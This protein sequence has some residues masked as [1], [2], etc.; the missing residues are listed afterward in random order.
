M[1]EC[2]PRVFDTITSSNWS[3]FLLLFY[4]LWRRLSHCLSLCGCVGCVYWPNNT[5]ELCKGIYT[6]TLSLY[7]GDNFNTNVGLGDVSYIHVI[8]KLIIWLALLSFF[9]KTNS[10]G[11][12]LSELRCQGP[13]IQDLW[14]REIRT[15][16]ENNGG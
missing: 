11:D 9:L 16:K 3:L 8:I 14:A 5:S 7:I 2:I 10:A 13:N 1:H 6:I 4:E 15:K 12:Y